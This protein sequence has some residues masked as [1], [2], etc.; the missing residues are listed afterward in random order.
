MKILILDDDSRILEFLKRGLEAEC[1]EVSIATSPHQGWQYFEEGKYDLVI[2][3]IFLGEANGLDFCR[4]LRIK[5]PMVPVLAMTAK[6]SPEIQEESRGAGANAYLP[7]PFSFDDLV[8]TIED[9]GGN[10]PPLNLSSLTGI[11][12]LAMSLMNCCLGL[13]FWSV[14]V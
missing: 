9:L 8:A 10:S 4:Q 3:D 6:D 11:P 12:A 7:K 13:L 2:L 5:Q 14:I 1:H